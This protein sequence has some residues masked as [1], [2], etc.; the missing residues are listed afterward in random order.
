MSK[1]SKIAGEQSPAG[2][3]LKKLIDQR[4]EYENE[5]N[6][7]AEYIEA[8][9]SGIVSYRVDGYEDILTTR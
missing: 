4:S 5:L 7:G 1:K 3:Y 9:K 8:T 6:S 2:S